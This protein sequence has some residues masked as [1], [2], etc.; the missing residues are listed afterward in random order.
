[1]KVVQFKFNKKVLVK[2]TFRFRS[3]VQ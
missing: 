1:M 3:A 2:W